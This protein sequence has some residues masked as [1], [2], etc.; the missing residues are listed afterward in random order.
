ML[1]GIQNREIVF[2]IV[3]QWDRESTLE[4]D[5]G[6]QCGKM[7][8]YAMFY[9]RKFARLNLITL[10]GCRGRVWIW[11]CMCVYS[12][13]CVQLWVCVCVCVCAR[14]CALTHSVGTLG[15]SP[16]GSSIHGLFQARILERVA[17]FLL[18]GTFPIQGLNSCL[19]CLL[20]CRQILY[21]LSHL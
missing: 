2:K 3:L 13:S 11:V 7:K 17:I 21:P 8:K 10:S 5:P 4:Q 6:Y 14:T 1:F 15:C 18:Q 19:F 9:L 12:L 16:P 20:H